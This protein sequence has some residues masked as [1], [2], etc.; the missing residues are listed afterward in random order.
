MIR[1]V[2]NTNTF[3]LYKSGEQRLIYKTALLPDGNDV[4]VS[5]RKIEN[6]PKIPVFYPD[7]RRSREH[8]FKIKECLFVENSSANFSVGI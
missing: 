2:I 3:P 7:I 1:H 8:V 6:N 4:H 5:S